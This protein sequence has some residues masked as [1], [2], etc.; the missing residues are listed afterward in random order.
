LALG[1]D[2][3]ADRAAVIDQEHVHFVAICWGNS[4]FEKFVGLFGGYFWG[5]PFEAAGDAVDVGIDGEY[6][7]GEGEEEEAVDGF[8]A[9]AFELLKIADGVIHVHSPHEFEGDASALGAKLAED[10]LDARGL[11]SGKT[12]D[13]NP[14]FDILHRGVGNRIPRFELPA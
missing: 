7:H 1:S 5:D 2:C 11:D 14:S 12:G 3:F 8:W 9:D 10:R 4:G 13:P 6:G